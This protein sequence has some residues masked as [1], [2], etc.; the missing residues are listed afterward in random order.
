MKCFYLLNL[1]CGYLNDYQLYYWSYLAI[2]NIMDF[3]ESIKLFKIKV[4]I[5]LKNVKII[6]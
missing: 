4:N 3:I 1:T 5:D 2:D 6:F